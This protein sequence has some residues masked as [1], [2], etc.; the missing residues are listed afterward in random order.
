LQSAV[1]IASASIAAAVIVFGLAVG[2]IVLQ[3]MAN[4]SWAVVRVVHG[5]L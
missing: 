3:V 2:A 5:L 1:L 4:Y